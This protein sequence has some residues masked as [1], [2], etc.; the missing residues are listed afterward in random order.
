MSNAIEDLLPHQPP[1]R[2]ID[3][4]MECTD[5]TAVATVTFPSDSLA[6]AHGQVLET[7]LVECIAQTV[8]AALGHRARAA[9]RTSMPISGM[10]TSVSDFR[11]LARAPVGKLLRVEVR[12]L[13][14]LGM[15]MMVSGAV[16]CEGRTVASGEL[17]LYA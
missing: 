2:W 11:I 17:T 14:R 7:A 16:S 15:M 4:L 3:A 5:S 12:E 6:V 13:R 9:G 1:M 10:L 8:A